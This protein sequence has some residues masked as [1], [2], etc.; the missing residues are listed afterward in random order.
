MGRTA[1]IARGG[2]GGDVR[3]MT[4]E[5]VADELLCGESEEAPEGA[6]LDRMAECA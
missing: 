2:G 1:K 4:A 5:R 3:R 6:L